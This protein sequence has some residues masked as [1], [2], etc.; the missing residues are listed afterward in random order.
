[1]QVNLVQLL[2]QFGLPVV[3]VVF[4]VWRNSKREERMG[5]RMDELQDFQNTTLLQ[6]VVDN[7][8]AMREVTDALKTRPCLVDADLRPA[9]KELTHARAD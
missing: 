6:C 4:F 2:Q 5:R 1:M 9:G 3:L 7:T 8:T